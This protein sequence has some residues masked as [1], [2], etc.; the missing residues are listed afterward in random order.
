MINNKPI[1]KIVINTCFGGFAFSE[2]AARRYAELSG[3]TFSQEGED[4]VKA[5]LFDGIHWLELL[6]KLR[7]DP[8]FIQAVQELGPDANGD[9]SSLRI[10]ELP[11]GTLY[12]ITN[13]DGSETLETPA[14]IFWSIMP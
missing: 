6:P 10:L 5:W 12:R 7:T 2:K 11:P 14:S 3:K 1:S 9:F 8:H 4:W 13:Y